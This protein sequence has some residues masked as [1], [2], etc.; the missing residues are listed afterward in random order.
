MGARRP[1]RPID[2][3][4]RNQKSEVG[5][6]KTEDRRQKTE[7]MSFGFRLLASDPN[8]SRLLGRL[9]NV[10][11]KGVLLFRYSACKGKDLLRAWIHHLLLSAAAPD[12]P[13]M[14]HLLCRDRAFHFSAIADPSP[15]LA[16]LI[17]LF[18][19]GSHGPSPLFLEPA[20]SYVLHKEKT[21]TTISPLQA[22]HTKLQEDL[23]REHET[24]LRLLYGDCDPADL[25]GPEFQRLCEDFLAPIFAQGRESQ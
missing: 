21:R 2:L 12:Q 19:Q 6:Q 16:R 22:A 10:Y 3:E 24:E 7:G 11:E 15:H 17:E 20:W 23:D 5:N 8:G 14:T 9:E 18:R 1:D 13:V 4:I 25:L